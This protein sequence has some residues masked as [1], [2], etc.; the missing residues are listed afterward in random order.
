M[1]HGLA[2]TLQVIIGSGVGA[3]A[4]T[5]FLNFWKAELDF[6]RAKLEELYAATHRYTI[7]AFEVCSNVTIGKSPDERKQEQVKIDFERVDLLVNLYF[8]Q[9]QPTF[10]GFREKSGNLFFNKGSVFVDSEQAKAELL[11]L[12][13]D[14]EKLKHAIVKLAH[15]KPYLLR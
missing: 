9:L 1:P 14:G 8:P 6:R 5:F 4:V 2:T 7:S 12:Q 11:T 15:C 3:G 13:K 10:E